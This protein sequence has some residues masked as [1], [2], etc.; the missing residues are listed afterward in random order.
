MIFVF[1][2]LDVMAEKRTEFIQ[3]LPYILAAVDQQ[4]GCERHHVCQDITNENR[5]F[6]FQEWRSQAALDSH[7]HSEQFHTFRGI[8]YLLEEP[9]HLQYYTVL[10]ISGDNTM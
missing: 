1:Y 7:L 2:Q 5:F 3:S 4:P 6:I 9:P 10:T 8:F